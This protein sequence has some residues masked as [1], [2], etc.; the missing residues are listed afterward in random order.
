MESKRLSSLAQEQQSYSGTALI[1]RF[2]DYYKPHK[3]LFSLDFGSAVVSGVLEL[4]FPLAVQYFIDDLLPAGDWGPI[5]AAYRA[6][7]DLFR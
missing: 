2:A 3:K 1:K 4:A 6:G 5:V 7:N